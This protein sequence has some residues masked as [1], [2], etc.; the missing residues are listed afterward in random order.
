MS[1]RLK[2]V[3]KWMR[4]VMADATVHE[5]ESPVDLI[6]AVLALTHKIWHKQ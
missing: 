3:E 6:S 2:R 4:I 5:R 1:V